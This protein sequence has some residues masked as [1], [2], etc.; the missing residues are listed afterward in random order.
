VL[1]LGSIDGR[2]CV[3]ST[4]RMRRSWE[5]AKTPESV[6]RDRLWKVALHELGHTLG[7]E[8]CPTPGCIMEDGHGTVKTT[9]RDYALCD[10]CAALF[11]ESV[12]RNLDAL[13]Y[14]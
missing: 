11:N 9:D 10:R 1:G 4:F 5:S 13:Q 6:V 3:L 14:K 2:T 8:H 12:R 7:L